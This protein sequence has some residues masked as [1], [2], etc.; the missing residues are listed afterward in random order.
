MVSINQKSGLITP[1][2][3]KN[4]FDTIESKKWLTKSHRITLAE[5][6]IKMATHRK[7]EFMKVN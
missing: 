4:V 1:D 6:L 3:Y 5:I 7:L 2:D